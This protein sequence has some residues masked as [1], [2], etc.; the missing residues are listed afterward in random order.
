[1]RTSAILT[2]QLFHKINM[3]GSALNGKLS[4]AERGERQRGTYRFLKQ[5]N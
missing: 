1:M 3:T 2:L 5:V 4:V